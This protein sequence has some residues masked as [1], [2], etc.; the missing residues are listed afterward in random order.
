MRLPTHATVLLLVAALTLAAC[1][2]TRE[3]DPRAT[4]PEGPG[5]LVS[6]TALTDFDPAVT[7][8]AKTA[9]RITY[10][11]TTGHGDVSTSVTGSAFI[12]AGK[13]PRG[14][15]PVVALAHGTTGIEVSCGPSSSPDLFGISG[16]VAGLLELGQAVAVADYQGLGGPGGHPYLDAQT[17]GLNVI[18]S[19][20]AL[21]ALS[22]DVSNRWA[23][24]GASQGG[25]AAWAAN[26]QASDYAPEL[27]LV[28]TV[29]VAPPADISDFA[30]LAAEKALNPQQLSAYIWLLGGLQR[31]RPDF[32]LNLYVHDIAPDTWDTLMSC[33]PGRS[34]ERLRALA[35]L[36]PQ[37]VT[38]ADLE[39]QE[40]L[41]AL[42]STFSLPKH[43]AAAPMLIVFGGEDQYIRPEWTQ[44]AI[45]R[46]CAKGSWIAEV[47]QPYNTHENVDSSA[48]LGWVADRFD[49]DPAPANC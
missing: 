49:G 32:D 38:P 27:R 33:D 29:S 44:E 17:A 39:A 23:A 35:S 8:R 4:R 3:T 21:R 43:R 19:V 45:N 5:S 18:D 1:S 16:V 34:E 25:A 7:E 46:A 47:F 14:G 11:S 22:P 13:P 15:W 37:Q 28:G 42:L 36:T 24:Y 41:K 31:T 9:V 30:N 2:K 6:S 26:E 40:Q 48:V 20:R 12:P 10:R